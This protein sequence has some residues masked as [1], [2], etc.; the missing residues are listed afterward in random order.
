VRKA[1]LTLRVLL[2][3]AGILAG[4]LA[5]LVLV[6]FA[7]AYLVNRHDEP[8]TAETQALL[9]LPA[10][11]PRPE[12]NIYVA[13]QGFD[14]P[15]G[16]SVI[17]VGQARIERFNDSVDAVQR[18]P[19]PASLAALQ[20]RDPNRLDFKGD[21]TFL[22]PLA[23]SVWS[24]AQRHRAQIEQLLADN[25]EL[26]QR[27][28]G[29]IALR[30]YRE[31]ARPSD[32]APFAMT[33]TQVRKLFLAAIALHLRSGFGHERA[34]ALADL[35]SDIQLWRAV[36][37]ADGEL[38]WKMLSVAN[39]ESDYLLLA[40]V[41]ADD[42]VVLPPGETAETLVP[43]F[44]LREWDVGSAFPAEFRMI[45]S[46]LR[47]SDLS[48]TSFSRERTARGA[49]AGAGWLTS[50][51]SRMTG[52]FFKLNATENLLAR[53]T[54]RQRLTAADPARFYAA[55]A[56]SGWLPDNQSVWTLPLSYNPIGKI[57]VAVATPMYDSYPPRA[58]DGAALQRLV[59]AGY[60]IRRQRIAP[61]AIPAFL[62]QHPEVALHPAS[63]RP[64]LWDA[65]SGELRVPVLAQEPPGRRFS[66]HVW[67]AL[68][69]PAGPR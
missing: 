44:D 12:D 68:A 8:L 27:Y 33:P 37:V 26:Y 29:L 48:R 60:E 22:Q 9:R 28:L 31:T 52:H 15:P 3:W 4:S 56:V 58:W 53:E 10:D 39:L 32:Q 34:L 6:L 16:Q 13:L 51:E 43:L 18:D 42:Q 67:Q 45:C 35:E 21:V 41:I 61:E 62:R 19:T 50:A 69:R 64:F 5:L 38:L 25:S 54:T 17:A 40:D 11:A 65:A 59:R 63:G 23:G 46:F 36:L 47:R 7:V 57:L 2:S 1:W 14:A 20:A 24:T 55:R 30:S 66:I 49:G